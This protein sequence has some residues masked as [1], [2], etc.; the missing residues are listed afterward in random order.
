MKKLIVFIIFSFFTVS[1]F[2]FDMILTGDPVLEDLRFL[3]MKSGITVLSFTPPLAPVE[4][5][6]FLDSIDDASLPYSAREAYY[7]VRR[8]LAPVSRFSYSDESFSLMFDINTVLEGRTRFNSDISWFPRYQHVTPFISAPL[9]ASFAGRIQLYLEPV[10]SMTPASYSRGAANINLPLEYG[11]MNHEAVIRAFAVAGGDWWNFQIG[12]DRLFWGTGHTGS[13]TFADNSPHFDFA[14][15]SFFSSTVKYSIVVNQMPLRLSRNLFTDEMWQE[16]LDDD[17]IDVNRT[18]LQRHFYLHR[19]DFRLF[20]RLSIGIMEGIMVGDAPLELR[21]LNPLIYFHSLFS[22]N[23]FPLWR[24]YS[25][26]MVGSFFSLEVNWSINRSFAVYGQFSMNE[27]TLPGEMD[28]HPNAMGWM[29]GVQFAHS[30]NNW[31]SVSF[32][33]FIYTDPYLSILSS[34]F[35]SFIQMDRMGNYY[36]IGH[37]RDTIAV[38]L[39][40]NFFYRNILSFSGRFSWIASGQHNENGITWDWESGPDAINR[41]TPT[42]TAENKFVLS[43]GS[44]WRPYRRLTLEA[45]ITGI[46]SLNNNHVS[47]N[48]QTG[49]QASFSVGFQY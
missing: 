4:I 12:R 26:H 18:T 2:A 17:S 11:H 20:N 32:L 36:F 23:D 35:A 33:E 43:F 7:R 24:P 10:F 9:R 14:R 31:G 38:T 6:R 37:P 28:G 21:Y 44:R 19:L 45:N 15:L 39:G 41:R 48:N 22:W 42:G 13:M 49:G 1:L 8:R 40:S 30:F 47:G 3:S 5:E 46:V 27:F 25:G 29:A 34:P 16:I